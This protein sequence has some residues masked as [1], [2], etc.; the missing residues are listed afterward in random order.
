MYT[1]HIR[2]AVTFIGV[3]HTQIWCSNKCVLAWGWLKK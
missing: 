2:K 3:T 1:L